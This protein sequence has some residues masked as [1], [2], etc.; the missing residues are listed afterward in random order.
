M[1]DTSDRSPPSTTAAG[2]LAPI[3]PDL[4][5]TFDRAYQRRLTAAL[6]EAAATDA[7]LDPDPD[8]IELALLARLIRE[9]DGAEDIDQYGLAP[10]PADADA[11]FQRV[12]LP[13]GDP[14]ATTTADR[15][16]GG[17]TAMTPARWAMIAAVLVLPLLWLLWPAGDPAPSDDVAAGTPSVTVLAAAATPTPLLDAGGGDIT[18]SSPASLDLHPPDAPI[19]VLRVR[20]SASDLGGTWSPAI[21]PGVAAWLNGTQVNQVFC[22]DPVSAGDVVQLMTRGATIIVRPASGAVRTF[23]VVRQREVGRQE[24]EVL[25]QRRAGLTLVLCGTAGNTRLVVEATEALASLA[26]PILRLATRAELPGL[27]RLAPE[28]VTV[29][30]PDATTPPGMQR[31]ALVATLEN[32]TAA[33]LRADELADQ[34]ELAGQVVERLPI[35]NGDLDAYARQTVTFQY[36]V[37]DTGGAALWR[38]QAPTG[39]SQRWSLTIPPAPTRQPAWRASLDPAQVQLVEDGRSRTLQVTL[40]VT[41]TRPDAQLGL[42][43]LSAWVGGRALATQAGTTPLPLPLA[44][45]TPTAVTLVVMLPDVGELIVQLGDTRWRVTLP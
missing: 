2:L 17:V 42:D 16:A 22:L 41:A 20:A 21:E 9:A 4:R 5:Q 33:P 27:A 13:D 18:V 44:P 12:P 40:V 32:L 11:P 31:V 25:D 6:A 29:G 45:D 36:L 38:V 34:L 15:G 10:S 26:S 37:P 19:E 28:R 14:R 39:E 3:P 1:T 7:V 24:V 8:Q 43:D 23:T 35:L 30:D